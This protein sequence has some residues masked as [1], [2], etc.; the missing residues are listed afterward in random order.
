MQ[1]RGNSSGLLLKFLTDFKGYEQFGYLYLMKWFARIFDFYLDASIHVALSVYAL[2][3][4]TGI[5]L[6]FEVDS[7]LSYFIFFGTIACYNFIKYGVEAEKYIVVANRYHRNIQVASFVALI[8][9]CYHAWFLPYDTW[10]S[11]GF[12]LILTGLY[13]LP[14]FPGIKN[15]RSLGLLKIALVA[16]VWSGATVV[17]SF[18]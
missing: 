1:I 17:T 14:I 16:V 12:V 4:I 2:I 8:F 15:L 18:F 7:H 10:L 11:I 6:Q 5:I 3:Q 13:A 9:V